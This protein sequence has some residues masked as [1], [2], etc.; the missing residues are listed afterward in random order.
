MKCPHCNSDNGIFYQ[1]YVQ[2]SNNEPVG[3][4]YCVY[5]GWKDYEFEVRQRHSKEDWKKLK[6]KENN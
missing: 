3:Y 4:W 6:G 5:C 1:K 2:T